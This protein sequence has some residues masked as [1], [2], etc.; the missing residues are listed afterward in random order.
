MQKMRVIT[1]D[2]A[3]TQNSIHTKL[4]SLGIKYKVELLASESQFPVTNIPMED[5]EGKYTIRLVYKSKSSGGSGAGA[6]STKLT[7]SAQCMYAALAFK[8]GRNITNTDVSI[9][10]FSSA[11]GMFITDETFENMCNNLSDDW[12][13][14]CIAGANK[15][16][17]TYSGNYTFHRGSPLV[18]QI[19][20]KFK[21]IKKSEGV[22]MD[23]NK[24]S[25]ADI[26][27]VRNDFNISSILQEQTLLGL[28]SAIG[29]ELS[30]G[31]L[32]GV[33]LKKITSGSARISAKNVTK[34]NVQIVYTGYTMSSDSLDGYLNFKDGNKDLKIQ[35]RTFG[36]NS[37]VG[38]QG[39]LKG[40][41]AN[42]GKIS[43]GPINMILR[44]HGVSQ[45]RRNAAELA[46]KNDD[47]FAL[48]I[49]SGMVQ[50]GSLTG[51]PQDY[52]MWVKSKEDKWRY[53][54]IQV[55]DLL[56]I[57]NSLN[58]T[59]R[60]QIMEDLYL[61]AASQSR[62]SAPYMKME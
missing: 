36:G 58:P 40:A 32:I 5:G 8:L 17:S 33:S 21:E 3:D 29:R 34:S 25:P 50:L 44:T 48:D 26:Y 43:L 14:S 9:Q 60:N 53:S 23:I 6:D 30:A 45:I 31:R 22:S 42:Q 12:I 62:F 47:N 57:M 24:W 38:W 52:V 4:N 16:R 55:I 19:E 20:N 61:Y 27:M 1:D 49:S 15:L 2:R 28:N 39:E 11:N 7:E 35:F 51:N 18:D 46:K 37:L 10:N 41:S 54:K 59:K 56:K 13:K